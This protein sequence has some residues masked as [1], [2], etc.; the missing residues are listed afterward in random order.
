MGLFN[1]FKESENSK[2]M[3]AETRAMNFQR[4][5]DN[6]KVGAPSDAYEQHLQEMK[7]DLIRWQQDLDSDLMNMVHQLLSIKID[8]RGMVV[9]TGEEPLCNKKF[10]DAV[11]IPNC[12][13]FLW[14]NLIN[15]NYSDYEIRT[16]LKA[17]MKTIITNMKNNYELYDIAFP[18]YDNVWRII[19]NNIKPSAFRAI[20][21]WTKRTDSTIFKRVE[22]SFDNQN[23]QRKK[24]IFGM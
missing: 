17:T 22:S 11:V 1:W 20:E 2:E 14:K 16:T 4:E 15:T 18:Q 7:S 21:G 3:A 19:L 12:K 9:S 6:F 13:P 10:I 23:E 5:Q 24:G 8:S